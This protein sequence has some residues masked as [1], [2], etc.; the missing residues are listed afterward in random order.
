ML[1]VLAHVGLTLSAFAQGQ[2]HVVGPPTSAIGHWR[3]CMVIV[4]T[5][6]TNVRTPNAVCGEIRVSSDTF[7]DVSNPYARRVGLK[8]SYSLDLA[9]LFHS[10][11]WRPVAGVTFKQR[12]YVTAD[13][14]GFY[15]QLGALGGADNGSVIAQVSTTAP[16]VLEGTWQITCNNCDGGAAWGNITLKR[17]P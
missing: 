1:V 11:P 6:A 4:G 16:D 13:S 17:T 12:D 8:A 10:S 5:N 3:T 14:T 15:F 9:T 2:E 7:Y